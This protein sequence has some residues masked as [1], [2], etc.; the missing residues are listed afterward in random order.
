MLLVEMTVPQYVHSRIVVASKRTYRDVIKEVTRSK[1]SGITRVFIEDCPK[2]WWVALK[3]KM[4]GASKLYRLVEVKEIDLPSTLLKASL[5]RRWTP[6]LEREI[7]KA[8][9]EVGLIE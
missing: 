8:L 9:R 3:I 6:S 4:K 7:S 1:A 2:G 5:K